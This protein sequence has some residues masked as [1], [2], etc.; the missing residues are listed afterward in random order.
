MKNLIAN[1][2]GFFREVD[3]RLVFMLGP[4][5]RFT[6]EQWQRLERLPGISPTIKVAASV[7]MLAIAWI[8]SLELPQASARLLFASALLSGLLALWLGA[9]LWRRPT[10]K[11]LYRA[12]GIS[13]LLLGAP[14]GVF[15]ADKPLQWLQDPSNHELLVRT[16]AL[17]FL[18]AT[19]IWA[20]AMWRN[21]FMADWLHDEALRE[22]KL[23]LAQRLSSAQIQPH[24]LFNSLASLQHWVAVKDD[25]AAPLLQ[26]LTS[27]LRATLPLFDRPLLSVGEEAEA[28]RRYLEVMQA[29]LG[30]RLRFVLDIAPDAAA[31]QLPPGVLLTLVENAVEHGVQPQ[32]SGGELQ[33]RAYL[34]AEGG[35]CVEVLDDGPGPSDALLQLPPLDP[36][37]ILRDAQASLGLQNS[38][39]RLWQAF[40]DQAELSLSHRSE[41]GCRAQ[42]R[43]RRTQPQAQQQT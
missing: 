30:G 31:A 36:A 5:H 34:P 24:F 4:R 43:V 13:G 37:A 14:I 20:V 21:E 17:N 1:L 11:R 8:A 7:N 2:R 29:R 28:V 23:E 6:P 22:Q 16:F 26:S 27:Y 18:Y 9:D 41:G 3:W 19:A 39:L 40:G 10:Q 12:Y 38:R 33:L 42:V 32:L 25:R 35:L 15:M